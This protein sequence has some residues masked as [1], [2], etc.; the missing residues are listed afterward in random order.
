MTM[1][2]KIDRDDLIAIVGIA[3]MIIVWGIFAAALLADNAAF[4]AECIARYGHI[5]GM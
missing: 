1:D 2:T 5:C 4:N 3:T